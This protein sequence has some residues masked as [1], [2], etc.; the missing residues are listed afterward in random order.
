MPQG[1]VKEQTH[2][3]YGNDGRELNKKSMCT[4]QL[5]LKMFVN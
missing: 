5:H 1:I 3:T 4:I 2:F